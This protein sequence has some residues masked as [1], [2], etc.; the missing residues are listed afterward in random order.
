[1][2][3]SKFKSINDVDFILLDENTSNA[4]THFSFDEKVQFIF[5]SVWTT[6]KIQREQFQVAISSTTVWTSLERYEATDVAPFLFLC[7]FLASKRKTT[8]AKVNAPFG[9]G[10]NIQTYGFFQQYI[11]FTGCSIHYIVLVVLFSC[12]YGVVILLDT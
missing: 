10:F 5:L 9:F 3:I 8:T 7:K 11:R 6:L 2:D 12:L 1:M 4:N